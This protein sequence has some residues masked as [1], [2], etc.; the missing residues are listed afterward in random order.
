MARAKRKLEALKQM[1]C[2]F[3]TYD[4]EFQYYAADVQWNDP[5]KYTTLMRGLN[6]EIKDTITLSDNISQ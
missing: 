1:N 4:V 6:N 5:A 2:D 3:S